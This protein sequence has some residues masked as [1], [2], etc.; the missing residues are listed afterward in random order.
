[1]SEPSKEAQEMQEL[2][3]RAHVFIKSSKTLQA[4]MVVMLNAWRLYYCSYATM[5]AY[6]DG[7]ETFTEG[8]RETIKTIVSNSMREESLKPYR[9]EDLV[10]DL[11]TTCV[12]FLDAQKSN[13][14]EEEEDD[15]KEQDS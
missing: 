7:D 12:Q 15:D 10:A 11:T 6:V 9:V 13:I 14:E 8:E 5:N 1:M 2:M 3:E 4:S